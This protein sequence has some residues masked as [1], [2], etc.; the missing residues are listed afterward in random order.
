VDLGSLGL[1]DRWADI[2]VAAWSTELNYGPGYADLICTGYG[3][4]P[5]RERLAYYR[6]L[7]DMA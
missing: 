5:D 3:I 4:E 6:L 2:A 7:W 1:A